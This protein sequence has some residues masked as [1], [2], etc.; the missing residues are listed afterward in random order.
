LGENVLIW[1]LREPEKEIGPG[2]YE[3]RLYL[4]KWR[5]R[6]NWNDSASSND[7]VS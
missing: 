1:R 3:K 6:G 5:E 4:R 7:A 2:K